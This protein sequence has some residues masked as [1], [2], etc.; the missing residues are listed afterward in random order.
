MHNLQKAQ[1][2][3]TSSFNDDDEDD[4]PSFDVS[5]NVCLLQLC[6][7]KRSLYTVLILRAQDERR[8]FGISCHS[9][10]AG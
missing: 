6:T 10:S 1:K 4:L 9:E 2:P 3:A 8:Y 5:S 7:C